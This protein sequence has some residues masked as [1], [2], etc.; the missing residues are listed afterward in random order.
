MSQC[1]QDRTQVPTVA[2]PWRRAYTTAGSRHLIRVFATL[3]VPQWFVWQ[4]AVTLLVG[5]AATTG[6]KYAVRTP[7]HKQF[8]IRHWHIHALR[9]QVVTTIFRACAA[10]S[11]KTVAVARER[12]WRQPW[13]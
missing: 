7:R 6:A 1:E 12:A 3:C 10:A 9:W 13:N 4:R 8:S 11:P 2:L 5:K